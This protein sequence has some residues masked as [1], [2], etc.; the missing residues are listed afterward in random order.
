MPR[1][2]A[3][4]WFVLGLVCA[5]PSGVANNADQQQL[6][7]LS[8]QIKR[9]QTALSQGQVKKDNQLKA[10][11]QSE[12][13]VQES[14]VALRTSSEQLALAEQN[15]SQLARQQ[16]ALQQQR[17]QQQQELANQLRG[18]WMTGN[19]DSTALLLRKQDP[20]M[21]ERIQIYYQYL[22]NA[23]IQAITDVQSTE[24]ELASNTEQQQQW[25]NQQA[26]LVALHQQQQAQLQKDIDQRARALAELQT[27][28]QQQQQQLAQMQEDRDILAAAIDQALQ[29]LQQDND[30]S[31]LSRNNRLPWPMKARLSKGFGS[32]R[33][34]QLSWDGWLFAGPSGQEITAVGDGRVIFADWLRGF[35]L[36]V[37]VDH[38]K[39]YLSLYGHAQALL[40]E[41]GDP[42]SSGEIL[43]L[44]GNSGGV[45]TPG[46]YFEIRHRGRAVDPKHFLTKS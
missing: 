26:A 13:A 14:T 9:H 28:L 16:Q 40:K 42:V 23:R 30:Y 36:V 12:K 25:R 41:V 29:V 45:D 17:L 11:R 6:K 10:L 34:G 38:G 31:G 18:A 33:Q 22:N 24:S 39:D 19:H 32:H 37:V 46:L 5:S 4:H 44:S 2:A 35:G 27:D 1:F 20:K 8:E 43:A 7:Q 3:V 15:L 21:R